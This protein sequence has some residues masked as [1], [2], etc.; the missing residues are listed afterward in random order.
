M[1]ITVDPVKHALDVVTTHPVKKSIYFK[2]LF[3]RNIFAFITFHNL[4]FSANLNT[5]I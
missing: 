2:A 5:G 3:L 1:N 4:N